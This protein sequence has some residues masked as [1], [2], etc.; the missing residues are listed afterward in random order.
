L[1]L[2]GRNSETPTRAVGVIVEPYGFHFDSKIGDAAKT[3]LEHQ[4]YSVTRLTTD[5]AGT[6]DKA[7]VVTVLNL[8]EALDELKPG[9]LVIDTHGSTTGFSVEVYEKTAAGKAQRDRVFDDLRTNYDLNGLIEK[10]TTADGY[11][12]TLT[13]AGIKAKFTDANSIVHNASCSGH[14]YAAAWGARVVVD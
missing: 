4:H 13:S 7:P 1:L 6:A 14:G 12:I 2:N 5:E 8:L 9:V 10:G 3:A 11:D